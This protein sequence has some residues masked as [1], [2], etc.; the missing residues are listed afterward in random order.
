MQKKPTHCRK[1][2]GFLLVNF[3]RL[4]L[5]P[6]GHNRSGQAIQLFFRRSSGSTPR[7]SRLMDAGSGTA[8]DSCGPIPG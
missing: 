1:R 2:I 4:V 5:C 3:Y 8:T 6:S 7:T